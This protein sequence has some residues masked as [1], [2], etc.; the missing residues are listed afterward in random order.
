MRFIRLVSASV[1]AGMAISALASGQIAQAASSNGI[2]N[3]SASQIVSSAVS[4]T[5]KA[6]SFTVN[7]VVRSGSHTLAVKNLT[8]SNSSGSGTIAIGGDRLDLRLVHG[9][10]YLNGTSRFWVRQGQVSSRISREIGGRWIYASANNQNV[11]SFVAVLNKSEFVNGLNTS[12]F[13]NE[14]K[15]GTST[16][17]GQKVIAVSVTGKN[18][19][20]NV[21]VATTGQPYI[22]RVTT[23]EGTR[24][25]FSNYNRS[26][27]TSKPSRAI[28]I[29]TI[30]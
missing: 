10:V 22:I 30:H 8:I 19:S 15:G 3:Q 4:A 28:S 6:S 5:G 27:N 20:G 12:Q 9:V 26:V 17:N 2:T 13:T 1:A 24:V 21:Y 16:I 23:N 11:A 7:G 25:T 14:K 18:T 29:T